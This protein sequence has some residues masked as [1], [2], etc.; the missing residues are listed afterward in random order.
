MVLRKSLIAFF[1][2]CTLAWGQETKQL[3]VNFEFD[4]DYQATQ[5]EYLFSQ[6]PNLAGNVITIKSIKEFEAFKKQKFTSYR[7]VIFN[8][9]TH[10]SQAKPGVEHGIILQDGVLPVSEITKQVTKSLDQG[11][12]VALIDTSCFSGTNFD[13]LDHIDK[14]KFCLVSGD[15]QNNTAQSH[16]TNEMAKII[17]EA[18]GQSP[19]I[20]ELFLSSRSISLAAPGINTA[21]G[22]MLRSKLAQLQNLMSNDNNLFQVNDALDDL[23]CA[24]GEGPITE[25]AGQ[26][27][28]IVEKLPDLEA[29]EKAF[30]DKGLAEMRRDFELASKKLEEYQG[31][32]GADFDFLEFVNYTNEKYLADYIK[33]VNAMKMDRDL[34][35]KFLLKM[36]PFIGPEHDDYHT[37]IGIGPE[38]DRLRKYEA[39]FKLLTEKLKGLNEERLVKDVAMGKVF[40]LGRFNLAK[41]ERLIYDRLYKQNVV[42]E[43]HACKTMHFKKKN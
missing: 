23:D 32:M 28:K 18:K 15:S 39:K 35:D 40:S 20:E 19:S 3:I 7:E 30:Y 13:V 1:A 5:K 25:L 36:S 10:G 24:S 41:A 33:I 37:S 27:S 16:F 2:V 4:T 6:M 34:T 8:I 11:K 26:I 29:E 42:P 43:D 17:H 9:N 38:V 12:K 31:L 22:L 14:K 21:T